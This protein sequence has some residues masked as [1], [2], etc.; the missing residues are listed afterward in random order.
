MTSP[1]SVSKLS[2]EFDDFLFAPVG[3]DSN[4]LPLTVLSTLARSDLDPWQ[5]AARLTEAPG[6]IATERL[7]MLIT[8][9]P[10]RPSTLLDSGTI[11]TRRLWCKW[12]DETKVMA[13]GFVVLSFIGLPRLHPR[14]QAHVDPEDEADRG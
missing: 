13:D 10:G 8:S 5:E 14:Q 2:S 11:A 1:S 4:G 6:K 3:E 9:L 12:H 7:A